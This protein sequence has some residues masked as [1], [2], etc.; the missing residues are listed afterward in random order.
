MRNTRVALAER[1]VKLLVEKYIE[2]AGIVIFGWVLYETAEKKMAFVGSVGFGG[3]RAPGVVRSTRS[4]FLAAPV[5]QKNA[6][7]GKKAR[8]TMAQDAWVQLCPTA[9]LSP[10]EVKSVFVAEQSV[11]IAC[12]FDGQVYASANVCPH[13]GTPLSDGSVGDGAIVCAQHKSSFDLTTGALKGEWCPY[14]PLIGPLLG[15]L[16]PP[17]DLLT[18]AVR[19]SN[20]YVEALINVEAR[21]DFEEDYWF[22]L[23]DARGKATGDYH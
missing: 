1:G 13:L 11:L 12:D 21:K 18:Y 7:R 16:Q 19:E 22:G 20:G 5:A 9:D 15:K 8:V 2:D 23:L 3:V 4:G 14:P 17:R 10:G 6:V